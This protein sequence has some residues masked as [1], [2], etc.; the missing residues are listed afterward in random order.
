MATLKKLY[1]ILILRMLTFVSLGNTQK[2]DSLLNHFVFPSDSILESYSLED[3]ENYRIRYNN[4]ITRLSEERNQLL[5]QGISDAELFLAQNPNSHVGDKVLMR[6]AELYYEREHD[7]FQKRMQEYDKLYTL[8]EKRE[9]S[10]PPPE[11]RK[12]LNTVIRTYHSIINKYP[13]SELIDDCYYNI[14]FSYEEIFQA[15]SARIYYFR[16]VDEFKNSPLLADVY[17]RLGENYFNPPVNDIRTAIGYYEKVLSY[18]ESPRYDE[19]LYRLGW[20]H[21]RL[22]EYSKAISYFTLLVD[23]VYRIQSLDPMHKYS[24]PSLADESIEYIG[25][26]FL[27]EGGPDAVV[28]YLQVIGGRDYGILILKRLG[29]AYMDEKEN[30]SL[31]LSAYQNLLELYPF[32]PF[33]PAIQ[34]RIVQAHRRMDNA[35]M[36]FYAREV[37]FDTY[38]ENSTWWIKNSDKKSRQ[39][40]YILTESALRDNIS[41]LL[42][43]G[44]ETGQL[45]LF[46][47]SVKESRRYLS[48]FPSDSSAPLIH[49][50]MALMLDTKLKKPDEAYDEYIKMSHTYWDT[51]YQRFAA[52]N[53][54]ALARE[55]ALNAIITAEEQAAAQR[56]ITLNELR[57]K[58]AQQKDFNF[59]DHLLLHPLEL[60]PL[61]KRLAQAYDNYIMLFPHS[62][63][64]PLFL[65]NNGVLYYRRN[66]FKEALKYFNTL[67][68]H[69]P[70]SE[71]IDQ[72]RYAIMESYFGRGDFQSSE[73]IAR[74]I[75]NSDV[76]E[77]IKFK[78]RQRLAESVFLN[79]ELLSQQKQYLQA[80]N[81]Y[82]RVVR[83]NSSAVF[84][85]LALFNAALEYDKASDFIRAMEIYQR[86]VDSYSKSAHVFDALNNLAFDYAELGE[87]GNA[88]RTCEKLS[89]IHADPLK[90][91]DALYN[92]N[93]YYIKAKDWQGAITV[94]DRFLHKYPTDSSTE[95]IAFELPDL[96][97]QLGNHD[98]ML[99]AYDRYIKNYPHSPRAVEA[100]L[101]KA[102]Q[103]YRVD[104][105][106]TA[107]MELENAILKSK[108]L[109]KLGFDKNEFFAAEAEF[110]LAS[111]QFKEYE[112]ISFH[113][114][115]SDLNK[116]KEHK[117]RLLLEIV[118]H[119]SNAASYGT[120]RLYEATFMIGLV[121]QN[122]AATWVAQEIPK[123]DETR[124]IVAQKEINDAGIKL[125]DGAI[126][127]H[128]NAIKALYKLADGYKDNL[129][130]EVQ[131]DSTQMDSL[132][133]VQAMSQDTVLCDIYQYI[134]K[135]KANLSLSNYEKGKIGL[136]SCQ[137][138]IKSPIPKGLGAFPELIYRKQ[139]I[140]VAITPV[141]QETETYLN[142]GLVQADSFA[143]QSPYT[144]ESRKKLLFSKNL[145][146]NQYSKIAYDGFNLLKVKMTEYDEQLHRPIKDEILLNDLQTR[147][148]EIANLVEFNQKCIQDA[149]E[150]FQTSLRYAITSR[151]DTI[152]IDNAKDSLLAKIVLFAERS[153]SLSR[154]AKRRANKV[155]DQFLLSKDPIFE[156][157]LFAFDNIYLTLR[158][159]E[160]SILLAGYNAA[161]DQLITPDGNRYLL[162]QLTRLDPEHYAVELG[163]M[164]QE[165]TIVTDTT[166]LASSAYSEGWVSPEFDDTLWIPVKCID[167]ATAES[168]CAVW[169][170]FD[171][172]T[173]NDSSSENLPIKASYFFRKSVQIQG[174]PVTGKITVKLEQNGFNLFFNGDHID[175]KVATHKDSTA[176]M[177]D[178]SDFLVR[179]NNVIAIEV[180]DIEKNPGSLYV[181]STIK[182]ISDWDE[183]VSLYRTQKGGKDV[184]KTDS[185][186]VKQ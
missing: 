167:I 91:R 137:S 152:Y 53:A 138:F 116:S 141:I 16:I 154:E 129:L 10:E 9:L 67:V 181:I 175:R 144:Q 27:E 39:Q 24:N 147:Y 112:S 48:N 107:I 95:E 20:S 56:K 7:N 68:K 128:K 104:Q 124:T 81:E 45:D 155:R 103:Y 63:E 18:K 132:Q 85:D 19:A 117:K 158:D 32:S 35:V 80:G 159:V 113:L 82:R 78:A 23:D 4:E 122:F 5:R 54:V 111:L 72:A 55:A 2:P 130:R 108:E 182:T 51:R 93:L 151:F 179:G 77:E 47:Q 29:D 169:P 162:L 178:V 110:T 164:L 43:R 139:V 101:R 174:L 50:N 119:F 114:P 84:A 12:E 185:Q 163:L 115:E 120:V 136:Q 83:E 61:E 31:A 3:L 52:E 125:Y 88:A 143:I 6:L 165:T 150:H 92:A 126:R 58:A 26:S 186:K 131:R 157:G 90:S 57:T 60:S 97:R 177:Y 44:Q 166:W 1:I 76:N 127:A 41:V 184:D 145:I 13:Q 99:N 156:E 25:L 180:N 42:N 121:Y 98:E 148:D 71:E 118:S 49:W 153:D 170:L 11:P 8:Y 46:E 22:N 79:A 37:L 160:R 171:Q 73:I 172:K 140:D 66:Q 65:A 74:R 17:M 100:F 123:M 86:L 173:K 33:A 96:Y 87:Y 14:A 176:V 135:A 40:A 168:G 134:D 21:Y 70:D 30:Y 133:I 106:K 94:A 69:F 149:I 146:P 59:R 28:R 109:G 62:K 36:A 64:T 38:K 89:E 105:G 102:K 142:Q 161:K 15:D 183:K 75:I 34:N